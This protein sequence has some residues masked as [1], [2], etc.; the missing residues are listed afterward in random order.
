MN[1]NK[2]G[3]EFIESWVAQRTG[4]YREP[5][6]KGT[7]RGDPVGLSRKKYEAAQMMVFYPTSMQIKEIAR[8]IG[9]A[10]GVLRT[11]RTQAEFQRAMSE[12]RI[13]LNIIAFRI[14]RVTKPNLS[15]QILWE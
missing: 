3:L 11:W 2:N 4:A 7:S 10:D 8:K 14:L 5:V 6:K 9:V 13:E 1:E 12:A 15:A